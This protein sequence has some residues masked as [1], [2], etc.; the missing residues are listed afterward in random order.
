MNINTK[1][2]YIDAD[3]VKTM[4]TAGSS[5][6][7]NIVLYRGTE[8]VLQAN[9][10]ASSAN[11]T[12]M[13]SFANTTGYTLD[14]GR[15]YEGNVNPVIIEANVAAWNNVSD[16]SLVSP[17]NGLISVRVNTAGTAVSTDL[18]NNSSEEYT[19][20]IWYVGNTGSKILVL[21]DGCYIH[22]STVK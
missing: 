9:V 13:V 18:A 2:L 22:N 8:Y 17:L 16:W 20:E 21:S 5:S 6:S 3:N 12:S 11:T 10:Y 1:Q 7:A 4:V 19:M 14:I 15:A